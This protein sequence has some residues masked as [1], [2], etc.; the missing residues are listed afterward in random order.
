[1]FGIFSLRSLSTSVSFCEMQNI[2]VIEIQ[3][4]YRINRVCDVLS[5]LQ[6]YVVN[7]LR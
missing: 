5:P 2:L 7:S 3:S 6:L 1:M 4:I